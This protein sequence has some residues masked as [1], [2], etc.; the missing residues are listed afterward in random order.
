MNYRSLISRLSEQYE[1]GEARAIVRLLLESR[2]SLSWTEVLCGGVENFSDSQN[3]ELE[4]LM[5]RLEK[6]EPIQYVLGEAEFCGHVFHV[7]K[8]V[9]IPRIETEEL[10]AKVISSVSALVKEKRI[11]V[12]DIGTGSGCI[13]ISIALE[14][15]KAG[16]NYDVEALD[17]SDEALRIA[18]GNAENLGA[19]HISFRKVDILDDVQTAKLPRDYTIIV[20]NPPYICNKERAEM[21]QHVLEHE[22]DLALFVPDS[23]PFLFYRAIAEFAKCHLQ[24]NG[25]LFFE[26]NRAYGKETSVLIQHCG[27]NDVEVIKDQFENDRIVCGQL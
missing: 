17:I 20:S 11:K 13:A 25:K 3:V 26:I 5:S 7:E 23:D 15:E 21:E 9:L 19:K 8:G 16:K 18:S 2:F 14:L 6:G 1:A 27:F 10:V 24:L 12:L 22:P 4:S